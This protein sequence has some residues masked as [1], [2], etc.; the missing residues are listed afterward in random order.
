MIF[1][2]KNCGGNS[3]YSPKTGK[4]YCPHCE[5]DDSQE[6]LAGAGLSQCVNCG[7]PLE[8][9]EFTSAMKCPNC[10]SYHIF[11]ERIEG[12]YTPHLIL[13]FQ[14]SKEQAVESLRKEFGRRVF[15]P[16]TF[17]SHA[18]IERMEGAYVPFFLYG[19]HADASY[20]A[21]GTKVRSWTSGDTKYTETSYYDIERE[22]DAEFERIPVDA[23]LRMEN[24]TMDLLEP[25]NYKALLEFQDK[26]MSGFEAEIY[27]ESADALQMRAE[28]KAKSDSHALIR[29][30][31]TGYATVT[32]ETEQINLHRKSCEYALLPVWIYDFQYQG[33][34]Y[35]FHV[36]GQTGKIIGKTPVAH[37]KVI[38]YSATVFGLCLAAGFLVRTLLYFL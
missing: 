2:C 25:Y 23:S 13:P 32:Q 19:F 14:I 9:S 34:T 3:V 21:K 30:S 38:G 1:K 5:S 33:E 18:S 11:E 35:R 4:M 10:G 20:R 27:S 37:N 36:N 6:K 29:D 7:A 22:M 16:S 12:E 26:Y 8:V 28:S 17:L 24:N 31:V 15:T